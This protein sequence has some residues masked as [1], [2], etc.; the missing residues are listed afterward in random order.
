VTVPVRLKVSY[1]S[2]EALLGELTRSVGRGGVRIESQRAVPVGTRFV[3]ELKS[4]GL[5]R[6]VEVNGT[7]MSV[8]ESAPGRWVLHIRYEPPRDREGL[9]AVLGRIFATAQADLKRRH[10]R[11]PLQVRA[12]EDKPNS[13]VFRL[14]DISLG[15]VGID[16]EA[17]RLPEHIAVGTPFTLQMRLS[18]GT[19]QLLGE[20]SWA[21]TWHEEGFSPR[22]GVVFAEPDPAMRALLEDLL[23]LTAM[24]APP[25]I[26]RIA[27]GTGPVPASRPS[28]G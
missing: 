15:G 20:V 3:F 26:A 1:K 23:S 7:V 21:V 24:P 27:F 22:V 19:L 16:V 14:R 11:L 4:V 10:A 18:T 28:S 2:P 12:V 5:R 17:D 8:S 13:P 25:W 6:P 9:D